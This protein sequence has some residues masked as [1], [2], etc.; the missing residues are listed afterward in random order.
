MLRVSR[1]S[2]ARALGA[3]AAPLLLAMFLAAPGG[4][5]A[6]LAAGLRLG[7]SGAAAE[8]T[9]GL[10]PVLGARARFDGSWRLADDATTA[11]GS[12]GRLRVGVSLLTADL[13]AFGGGLRISGARVV[14]DDRFDLAGRADGGAYRIDGVQL[15]A[16]AAGGWDGKVRLERSAPYLGLGWASVGGSGAGGAG[17]FFSAELGAVFQSPPGAR[18]AT[19]TAGLM[20][21]LCDPPRGDPRADE[22]QV[23]AAGTDFKIY[24]VLA[25]GLGY[26]F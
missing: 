20:A 19:C 5:Q 24:P 9:Y 26:R 13:H 21:R 18:S 1:L 10:L 22:V 15:L 23:G 25:L 3:V 11:G 16:S 8:L 4:V 14:G 12:H 6:Q 7:S 2:S 17:L